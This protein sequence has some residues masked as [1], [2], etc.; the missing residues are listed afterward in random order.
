LQLPTLAYQFPSAN[1]TDGFREM[2]ILTIFL[3]CKFSAT[4]TW[5]SLTIWRVSVWRWS[6]RVSAILAWHDCSS[7]F[8]YGLIAAMIEL[9][10]AKKAVSG[11]FFSCVKKALASL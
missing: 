10:S 9:T 4:I 8:A 2:A 7:L 1:I 5:F 3:T 6:R 11:C